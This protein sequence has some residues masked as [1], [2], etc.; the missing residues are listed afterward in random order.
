M[1][2]VLNYI[3]S[4]Y[5]EVI[6]S[7]ISL[8]GKDFVG[9]SFQNQTIAMRNG[10]QYFRAGVIQ[11]AE[12]NDRKTFHFKEGVQIVAGLDIVLNTFGNFYVS[13]RAVIDEKV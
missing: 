11:R 1:Y 3:L 13:A 5:Y 6:I 4:S 2:H 8:E 10:L 12:M 7:N 9:I